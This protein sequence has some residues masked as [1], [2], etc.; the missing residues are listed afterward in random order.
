MLGKAI[1]LSYTKWP[2]FLNS[3]LQ[4]LS[5]QAPVF[6]EHGEE[7]KVIL[8]YIGSLKLPWATRDTIVSENQI[9]QSHIKKK[10]SHI[11]EKESEISPLRKGLPE[12]HSWNRTKEE[13]NP[14]VPQSVVP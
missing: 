13:E 11:K 1:P 3:K 8:G 5:W 4:K 7:G 12:F 10:K 2:N 9:K 14:P 6:S